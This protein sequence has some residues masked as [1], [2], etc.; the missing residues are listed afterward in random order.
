MSSSR[1]IK[2]KSEIY[3][4][5]P[6]SVRQIAI[7]SP[8]SAPDKKLI[9]DFCRNITRLGIKTY[10]PEN[11]FAPSLPGKIPVDPEKR[12]AD[13]NKCLKKKGIDL[14][15][16]SRGGFGSAQILEKINWELLKEKKIPV[17]GYS[18]LTALH[19]AMIRKN[20]GIPVSSPMAD[21][22][23]SSVRYPLTANSLRIALEH[24][25][26]RRMIYSSPNIEVIRKKSAKAAIMP[27]NLTVFTSMIGSNFMPSVKGFI[28]LV[29]DI[30]EQEYKIERML[31]QLE[32]A[33]ILRKCSGLLFGKFT[34]CGSK[35]VLAEVFAKFAKSVSGPVLAGID[36][37]HV[38]RKLCFRYGRNIEIT[39]DGRI[40][41]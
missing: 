34:A 10:L 37:G 41:V 40:I 32:M 21:N 36:F 30:A 14:I 2:R 28:L 1:K 18:D 20:A 17:L 31:T 23:F 8:G 4:P 11:V 3:N 5:F 16:S 7:V 13:F 6:D 12:A 19:L 22:F 39:P 29:E 24:D 26:K 38:R 27:V 15:I 9:G 25:M 33:G 35:Y